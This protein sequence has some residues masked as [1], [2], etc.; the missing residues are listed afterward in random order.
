ML[1]I[2]ICILFVHMELSSG[3]ETMAL[4]SVCLDFF[5]LDH[6]T[7]IVKL[8]IWKLMWN[9]CLSLIQNGAVVLQTCLNVHRQCTCVQCTSLPIFC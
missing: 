5:F 6:I 8:K 9:K 2:E 7:F 4:W 1:E 3:E